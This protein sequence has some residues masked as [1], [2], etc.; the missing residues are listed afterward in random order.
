MPLN[1][2]VGMKD[3]HQRTD[4]ICSRNNFREHNE[5]TFTYLLAKKEKLPVTENEKQKFWELGL[6][7][8]ESAKSIIVPHSLLL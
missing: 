8:F 5:T 3:W 7:G 6:L 1:L 4:L 2:K